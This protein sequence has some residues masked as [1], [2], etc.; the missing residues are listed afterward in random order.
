MWRRALQRPNCHVASR[1]LDHDPNRP[2]RETPCCAIHLL[3]LALC[4]KVYKLLERVASSTTD[5][6]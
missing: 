3:G 1:V 4:C 6:G 5:Q 2:Q